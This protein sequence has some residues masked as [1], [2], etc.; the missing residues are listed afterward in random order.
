MNSYALC[1]ILVSGDGPIQWYNWFIVNVFIVFNESGGQ[2][3]N[4]ID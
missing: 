1:T 4:F 3:S 2:Q